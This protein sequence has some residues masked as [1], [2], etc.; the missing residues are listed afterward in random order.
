[1]QILLLFL[2]IAAAAIILHAAYS[3]REA[4]A[5]NLQSQQSL[6]VLALMVYL[7]F[8]VVATRS[9]IAV[10]DRNCVLC[11]DSLGPKETPWSFG[12][13][14]FMIKRFSASDAC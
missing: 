1:M 12:A 13:L 8:L 11:S 2:N 14:S 5:A 6:F 4:I 9:K 7:A 3:K 10:L